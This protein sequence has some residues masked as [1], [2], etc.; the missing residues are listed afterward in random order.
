M[1]GKYG[2]KWPVKYDRA[3][4]PSAVRVGGKWRKVKTTAGSAKGK[5]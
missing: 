2:K 4:K 1:A 5:K 3:G